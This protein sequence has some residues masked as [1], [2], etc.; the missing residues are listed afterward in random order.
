[1]QNSNLYSTSSQSE[2]EDDDMKRF[3]L[4]S[5]FRSFHYGLKWIIGSKQLA[6]I[7]QCPEKTA[8][9]DFEI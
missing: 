6:Q 1:M 7:I 2:E 5:Y 8:N 3:W 9:I 4:F